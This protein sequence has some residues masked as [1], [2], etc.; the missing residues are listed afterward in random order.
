MILRPLFQW[1]PKEVGEFLFFVKKI[2]LDIYDEYD[3]IILYQL[4]IL[5]DDS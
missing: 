2:F 3:I 4:S 5:I 1:R